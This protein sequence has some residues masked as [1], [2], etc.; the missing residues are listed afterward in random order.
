M[1][2]AEGGGKG[3]Y[4]RIGEIGQGDQNSGMSETKCKKVMYKV[5]NNIVKDIWRDNGF[6]DGCENEDEDESD[7]EIDESSRANRREGKQPMY[8]RDKDGDGGFVWDV[9]DDNAEKEKAGLMLVGK[10]W[11]AKSTNVRAAVDVMTKLWSPK[12]AI[13]GNVIDA[14]N[15]I[16]VFR[17]SDIRDKNRVL[18]GQ[19]W[20]FDKQIWC[21]DEPNDEGK[22][23]DTPL[24][25][26]PMWVRI[27]DLPVRGR[28]NEANLRNLGEQLGKYIS[29]DVL[30]NPEIERAVR[31][32]VLH[33]VRQPLKATVSIKMPNGLT[34]DFEVKYERL[35]ATFCYGCGVFGH[36]EKE[37]E[38]GPYEEEELKFGEWMRASPWKVTKTGVDGGG[39]AARS[40]GVLFDRE[41]ET[42]EQ[43]AIERMIEKL[44]RVS[45]G[46]RAKMKKPEKQKEGGAVRE[47]VGMERLPDGG[48]DVLMVENLE[49]TEQNRE[50]G[51]ENTKAQE[52][53]QL[54]VGAGVLEP[55][56]VH[57]RDGDVERGKKEGKWRRM[58]GDE[59]L[60]RGQNTGNATVVCGVKRNRGEEEGETGSA[61][62][63]IYKQPGVLSG[64]EMRRVRG[65]MEDYDGFDVD[66]VGRSGGL[67]MMWR[68]GIQCMV[69]TV[70]VHHMDFD[71]ELNGVKWRMTGFYGWPSVSDRHLSWQL[72]RLL[73]S[74]SQ[75]P[76]I[77]IG[78]YNEIL[79]STEMSGGTRPQWQMNQ[80]RNA[81][82]DCG[83]RDMSF[84]G[85]SFTYDNGQ[86]GDD[87]RQSRID[88]AMVTNEWAELFPYSKLIHL[89]REWS[90]HSPIK[91][92]FDGRSA[93][94]R[95]KRRLFRFEQI[96]V[97][98]D[99]CEEAIQRAWDTGNFNLIDALGN[100]ETELTRWKGVSIGKVMRDLLKKRRRLQVLNEGAR[101][102][103]LVQERRK[104]VTE[105]AQL[106]KQEEIFWKQRSRA[107]WL[108]EGDRN[109]K[110]FHQKAGQRK[111]KN[112]IA[113][114]HDDEGRLREGD[115]AVEKVAVE[116]FQE[117]FT[118]GR[119]T[120]TGQIFEGVRNRVT[121]EMNEILMQ[122]YDEA[123]VLEALN[124]MHPL[125]APG[126]DGMNG[127]FYQTY[128]H[129]VGPLVM[130]TV[131]NVLR[132][133]EFPTGM[134][135]TFIVL[136]PK[137]KAPD[138]MSEFRPISL[139]N[140]TS[141]IVSKVLANRLK[142][143]LGEIVSENQSAFTPGRLIS[144]N[145]LVAFELFHHMKNTR[146]GEGHMALKLDMSK[147]YDRVEWSFLYQTLVSM[148][149]HEGWVN[150]V[151][152]CVTSVS[153]EV[154]INGN[155]SRLFKPS[156]GIR[157]G[158]PLSPYLFILCAE[159]MSSLIR[160][161]V[162]AGSIHGIRVATNAPVVSHLL[163][164]DD[165]ILFV[166]ANQL[167]ANRVKGILNRYE[168]A[169][170]QRVN[171]DKTTVSF[172]HC[173]TDERKR[174]IADCLGVEVVDE[175]GKYLGLPTVVGR[176][177]KAIAGC[178][179]DKLS[180]KLEGWRGKLLSK[181]GREILIKAVAQSIPTYAMSVFK[182]PN[183]FCDELR[184]L[185][186]QFWWGSN[187][188]K[189]KIP[190]I[191]W[192]KLCKAKSTGG[193]GFRDYKLFNEALLGKQ[194]WRLLT[195]RG[196]LMA[197]VLAGKYF[198]NKS[199]M[200]ADLGTNPSYTWRSIWEARC[201]LEKGIRR[202]IGD[203]LSTRVW[204]DAWIPGTQTGK[205]ISPRG[206]CDGNM[207]VASLLRPDGLTWDTS[208][209]RTF[210]LPFEQERI[211]S[212]RLSINEECDS[213]YWSLE[214]DGL[215]SVRSA[216]RTLA[217]DL[218]TEEE[219]SSY[220]REK[221]L[222][223]SIWKVD[224]WPRI[225]VFFWQLCR[226]ALPTN[227][228][229]AHRLKSRSELCPIC[230]YRPETSLHS[231][232]GCGGMG[233]VWEGLGLELEEVGRV[234]RVREWV[235][236]VWKI[237]DERQRVIFM[238]G[239]W[240]KWEARNKLVFEGR[241]VRNDSIIRRVRD[242]VDEIWGTREECIK[243]R[244]TAEKE[245]GWVRPDKGMV[246]INIDAGVI[247]GVGTGWGV[248]CRDENGEVMWGYTEQGL[249]EMEPSEAEAEAILSGV[250][251]ALKRGCK[252]AVV[253]SDC[254]TIIEILRNRKRGR[255]TL[256][257]IA[258]EIL[259]L[260]CQFDFVS[261]SFVRRQ[262]NSVAHSLG[263]TRP[264]FVGR[265]NWGTVLP[266]VPRSLVSLDLRK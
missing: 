150:R 80:F 182:L 184:S 63:K 204:R 241:S 92:V 180:K 64:V 169:S 192:K 142:R 30:P 123:E 237:L 154:L 236:A 254:Q 108:S 22:L 147:A 82:D 71:V 218:D 56:L 105:I 41:K 245:G 149:L 119:P 11:A 222:W 156:R 113:K 49:G 148:G 78:D 259:S 235:E 168:M 177:K 94:N 116:Y 54:Q 24:F 191:A 257:S 3:E 32:R 203:G 83:L 125:K 77:C 96:W 158:D 219:Q 45:V 179:R 264:W 195:E 9:G 247:E 126:P 190:W 110:F 53:K 167:E 79:Y 115:E 124:Q 197:R 120:H 223:N 38:E 256:H 33:D 58:V 132:G 135:R 47:E 200:Q 95:T 2:R 61:A 6:D 163:F 62:K 112:F 216:Y 205:V 122:E 4:K 185:V 26:V 133:G 19:P 27:Y 137:K 186:S 5:R 28:S 157:Q 251:E 159:V 130:R 12:G 73:A 81:V 70:S 138:K 106:L 189:R 68:K 72:L 199:F 188:G 212:I 246:K 226:D 37:C 42:R 211:L 121:Q 153:F 233:R 14:K 228:N 214:K 93:S 155:P 20:H 59:G 104:L 220:H 118:T 89:D 193:L 35:Q 91:V 266:P 141:K 101:T 151:M 8:E 139:C 136:I 102:A 164:A 181:A 50:Q 44:Q 239:C 194:A 217:K 98:E 84:E 97:G 60:N 176:S 29:M 172:S 16:F 162:E 46:S 196:C 206:E 234:E 173:T 117:L 175:Q 171:Y 140:V 260:C 252:R 238:V 85:Y 18:E 100:C 215:Y 230:E 1:E 165:S 143:F 31:I 209:V 55:G 107:I 15:R 48:D 229:I 152:H 23:T 166:K 131:L 207:L 87:N 66:S 183:N 250:K 232:M 221:T 258:A 248:V 224:V 161:A 114:I 170:G 231:V 69:R 86:I 17:F 36:G 34:R 213:W 103:Q 7:E 67:S 134:N 10:L 225:K 208:K 240:A 242:V 39:K 244:G 52:E 210:F 128:W 75:Q 202:R 227:A 255:S 262:F 174:S 261:W 178:I 76:W 109:T 253:E 40:L 13:V 249:G 21:L 263:H 198:H 160:Q 74:E 265:R 127:L 243:E 144:D 187:G 99:G 25:L 43:E 129:V 145:I 146:Q 90:D 111:K 51:K 88:R 201:V 65:C 57:N